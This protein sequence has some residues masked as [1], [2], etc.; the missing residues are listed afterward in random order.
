MADSHP[1]R[2]ARIAFL[3][4]QI[5]AL[6]LLAVA[7]ENDHPTASVAARSKAVDFRRELDQIRAFELDLLTTRSPIEEARAMRKR[8]DAAGSHVAAR[9]LFKVELE[10]LAADERRRTEEAE[11]ALAHMGEA[12][13]VAA[14]VEQFRALPSE[15]VRR[16][17]EQLATPTPTP[18]VAH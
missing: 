15:V 5:E 13:L 4:E 12:E 17:I 16:V 8:A 14:I 11:R 2:I 6:L 7:R 10:L 1:A 9:D 3:E 18:T